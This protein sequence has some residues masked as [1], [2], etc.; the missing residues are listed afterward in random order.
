MIDD[1]KN[2]PLL[3]RAK[4]SGS[5]IVGEGGA[6]T[7]LLTCKYCGKEFKVSP[8]EA[9]R[10]SSCSKSCKA[11]IHGGS[12]TNI[13]KVWSTMKNR[14]QNEKSRAF[15]NYGGRGIKISEDWLL[16]KNFYRDMGEQPFPGAHLDRIDNDGD[17]C[18][19]NVR[20][21]TQTENNRNTRRNK[22]VVLNGVLMCLRQ[23]CLHVGL[24]LSSVYARKIALNCSHQ[25]AIE[26]CINYPPSRETAATIKRIKGRR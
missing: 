8:S 14:C 19:E 12:R 15:K 9:K 25:E 16:F 13:Y 23:A 1:I 11:L 2:L 18:K 21:A 24:K 3:L 26:S 7:V 5:N 17:Y 4:P 20:W 22:N 6:V 10:R